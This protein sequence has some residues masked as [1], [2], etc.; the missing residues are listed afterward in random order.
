MNI[1]QELNRFLVSCNSFFDM[2]K[3]VII[4]TKSYLTFSIISNAD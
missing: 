1:F 4:F 2:S 3:W